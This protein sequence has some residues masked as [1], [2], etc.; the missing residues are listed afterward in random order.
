[1]VTTRTLRPLVDGTRQ[2]ASGWGDGTATRTVAEPLLCEHARIPTILIVDDHPAFRAIARTML[3]GEGFTVVG[4]A[5]DGRTALTAIEDLQPEVVLLDVQLPDIDGFEVAAGA[6]CL[7][8][9]PL[10]VLTSS[11]DRADFGSLIEESGA[12]GF[13]AKDE[14]SGKALS[15][16]IG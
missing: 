11:R 13:I 12:R 14:L 3:E 7:E 8:A 1:M 15:A 6:C 4:E 5:G 9:A 10:V 2:H 16:L